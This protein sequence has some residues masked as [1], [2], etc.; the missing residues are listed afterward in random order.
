MTWTS[1]KILILVFLL[2]KNV[3]GVLKKLNLV[4]HKLRCM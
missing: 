3:L 4:Y 1:G 2:M